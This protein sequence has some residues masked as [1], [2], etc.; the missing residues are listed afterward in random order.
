MTDNFAQSDEYTISDVETL[1][2]I[3]DPFRLQIIELM[4]N[5]PSTVKTVADQLEVKPNKLYYHVNLLEKHGLIRVVHTEVVS[6]IIEK[7]YQTIARSFSVEPTLLMGADDP[8]GE[9][10]GIVNSILD[11]TRT[12]LTRTL[13]HGKT[14]I[15][16][17]DEVD[18]RRAVFIARELTSLTVQQR[19]EVHERL[20]ALF[21][22]FKA[23]GDAN[24]P[25]AETVALTILF[26][27][28]IRGE[29]DK[30]DDPA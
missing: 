13:Q 16:G 2:V 19:G 6:G 28:I 25:D 23:M 10:S 27:P 18:T 11:A 20:Q 9:M 29:K 4:A 5:E 7:W 8:A 26:F 21:A 12:D 30:P 15:T 17:G 24:H 22:E 3:A 14:P 1:K